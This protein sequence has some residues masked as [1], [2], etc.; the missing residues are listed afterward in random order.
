[1][2]LGAQRKSWK[3]SHSGESAETQG[4]EQQATKEQEQASH[5]ERGGVSVLITVV[6]RTRPW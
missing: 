5:S 4:K 2:S 1:M 6:G 3:S